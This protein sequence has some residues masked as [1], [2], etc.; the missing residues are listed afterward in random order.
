VG[1]TVGARVGDIVGTDVGLHVISA[2]IVNSINRLPGTSSPASK[3]CQ[4][5][6]VPKGGK[7]SP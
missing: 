2:I 3:S 4:L 5:D 6:V 7:L 1:A